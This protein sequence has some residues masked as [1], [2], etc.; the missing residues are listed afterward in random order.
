[1]SLL[2]RAQCAESSPVDIATVAGTLY[3]PS[4][5]GGPATSASVV[6]LSVAFHNGNLYLTDGAR[7]R[8]IARMGLLRPW[9]DCWIRWRINR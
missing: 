9:S 7:I 6:L 3:D 8:R 1:M 2:E 4:G 5:D